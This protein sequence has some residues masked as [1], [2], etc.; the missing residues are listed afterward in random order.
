MA[1][2]LNEKITVCQEEDN[3]LRVDCPVDSNPNPMRM[4]Y[5]FSM[6]T[7]GK[8]TIINTNVSGIMADDKFRR[9]QAYADFVDDIIRLTIKD[10]T[11]SENTTFICKISGNMESVF[12][13][14]GKTGQFAILTWLSD[15]NF[16]QFL[17]FIYFLLFF[18]SNSDMLC[19]QCISAQCC[20][21]A[22]PAVLPLLPS[23]FGP[24]VPLKVPH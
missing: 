3:D 17:N 23:A 4:E 19:H 13:E 16:G 8:E 20:S 10:F 14:P 6:A 7:R 1:S 9:D 11:V 21:D 22:L 15:I 18:R 5:E 12:I 2:V 24:D